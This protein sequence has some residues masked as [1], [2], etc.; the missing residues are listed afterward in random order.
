M[1]KRKIILSVIIILIIFVAAERLSTKKAVVQK[2]EVK[3]TI[4]VSTQAV[5]DSKKLSQKIQYPASVVGDQEIQI[6]AKSSGTIISAPG[7]IGSAVATGTLLAKIDDN[8]TLGTGD[9][10]L[11]SLQVQQSQIAVEQAKKAYDLA[12]HDYDKLNNSSSAT[13][14][15]KN[16]AKNKRDVA[17][18]TYENSLLGLT[19]SVDNHLITS[20]ISGTIIQKNVS[21]GDSVSAGQVLAIVSKSANV[22]IQFYVT[23]EQQPSFKRG[24]EISAT[25]DNGNSF[26]LIVRNI[27]ATADPISKR[28]LIEAYPKKQGLTGLLSG[29]IL[30]VSIEKELLPQT[31]DNLILP[32]SSIS[33]GQNES[34][35]FIVENNL[36]KKVPVTIANVTGEIAEVATDLATESRIIT[37]GNKLVHDG[38]TVTVQN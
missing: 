19:G 16:T 17:K 35:L 8:G 12:K 25:S 11:K 38:E 27:A 6:T 26:Q 32:L 20:P 1:Q 30:T 34:Y 7:N 28:F 10:G 37:A 29:T 15:E 36:A 14:S 3:K 2:E 22:K 33:V 13:S 5:G 9:Q 31:A 18:L 21:V 24:Q 4:A 23:A